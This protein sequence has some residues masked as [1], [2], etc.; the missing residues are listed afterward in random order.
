MN[1]ENNAKRSSF[2]FA[3][4]IVLVCFMVTAIRAGIGM[5]TLGFIVKPME[6]E[7][8][9]K[10]S[11]IT[12][13]ITLQ[14]A[15]AAIIGPKVG[16]VLDSIG[17]KYILTVGL[18]ANGIMLMLVSFVQELWQLALVMILFGGVTQACIG[19]TLIMPFITKWFVKRRGFVMGFVSAGANLGSVIIAPIIVS[20]MGTESDWR[21]AW[22]TIGLIPIAI[23]APIV[24]IILN[25]S[26]NRT[27]QPLTVVPTV[28]GKGEPAIA[29]M[30]FT[31][32]EAMRTPVF[33]KLIIAWNLI[34]FSMKGDLLNKIPYALEMNYTAADAA[35][36]VF[37]YGMLAI[38][39]KI[40]I[41]WVSDRIPLHL[42]GIAL[43]LFQTVALYMFIDA[44][45]LFTLYLA[46]GILSG[47][48]AGG[49]I[50]LMPIILAKY[51]GSK[52]QGALSGITISLLLFSSVGGP[53]SASIIRDITGSYKNG[54]MLYITLTF[55]AFILFMFIRKPLFPQ[56]HKV[57]DS[58]T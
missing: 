20:L 19:N 4:L 23:I 18:A 21:Y 33:W 44:P 57:K 31:V 48:S 39:G 32:K 43:A 50:A 27:P 52:F 49:L 3:W 53:L 37:V 29:E 46:Y 13:C 26:E 58:K 15:V 55:I 16:R 5:Q 41:G 8:G 22:F 10:S 12:L 1:Q 36:I 2:Q 28:Q 17:A 34:D 51:Y 47:L 35:G 30:T 24:F 40:L 45:N 7:M 9:W 11:V 54:F 42:I 14:L 6:A 25:K 38:T 56:A